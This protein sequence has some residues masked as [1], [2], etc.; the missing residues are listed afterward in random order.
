MTRILRRILRLLGRAHPALEGVRACR[1]CGAPV[2]RHRRHGAWLRV[3]YPTK[4][5]HSCTL[6]G[7]PKEQRC[8]W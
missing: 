4:E 7:A 3:D 1:K 6:R 8:V 5:L 2:L